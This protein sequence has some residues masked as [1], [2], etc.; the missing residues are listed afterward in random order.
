MFVYNKYSSPPLSFPCSQ[1]YNCQQM[2]DSNFSFALYTVSFF[3]QNSRAS[4]RLVEVSLNKRH[5]R[6]DG[7]PRKQ[8]LQ[9]DC[10]HD[11]KITFLTNNK[12]HVLWRIRILN[13]QNEGLLCYFIFITCLQLLNKCACFKTPEACV[14]QEHHESNFTEPKCFDE[15]RHTLMLLYFLSNKTLIQHSLSDIWIHNVR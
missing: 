3:P 11:N 5:K 13:T 1:T 10:L 8:G 4:L 2:F 15:L 7:R 12:L 14:L 9:T 6:N